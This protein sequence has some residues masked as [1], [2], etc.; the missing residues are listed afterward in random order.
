MCLS[1]SLNC[2]KPIILNSSSPAIVYKCDGGIVQ[3]I[4]IAD[5]TNSS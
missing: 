4:A 1:E 2:P 5:S 3:Y